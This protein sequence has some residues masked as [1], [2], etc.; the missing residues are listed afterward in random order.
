MGQEDKIIK[1]PFDDLDD[2]GKEF[3]KYSEE[4]IC[5]RCSRHT[6]LLYYVNLNCMPD[7]SEGC[8]M[9]YANS[10]DMLVLCEGCRDDLRSWLNI[11][12]HDPMGESI[13]IEEDKIK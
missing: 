10:H 12:V 9:F 8:L 7:E 13:F 2:Q 5:Q 11:P 3:L 1:I 4:G 6:D